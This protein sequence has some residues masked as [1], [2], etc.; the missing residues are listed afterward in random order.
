MKLRAF[1]PSLILSLA[2]GAFGADFSGN[3]KGEFRTAEG[4]LLPMALTLK[5]DGQNVTGNLRQGENG[6][7]RDIE[8]GKL[9]G[10][11]L[12]FT[13]SYKLPTGEAR[14]VTYIGKLEGSQLKLSIHREGS[15]RALE[16]TLERQ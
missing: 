1:I 14:K 6:A 12:T 2:F 11:E 3:W 4:G 10:D 15:K 8:E 9:T 13:T 5:V 7:P 16:A